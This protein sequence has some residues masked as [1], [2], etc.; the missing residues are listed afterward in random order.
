MATKDSFE[1]TMSQAGALFMK[2]VAKALD[3]EIEKYRQLESLYL[4]PPKV[5]AKEMRFALEVGFGEEDNLVRG[6]IIVDWEP[7]EDYKDLQ[8]EIYARFLGGKGYTKLVP[9][10]IASTPKDVSRLAVKTLQKMLDRHL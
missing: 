6:Y 2:R 5:Y 1:E 3:I 9:T 4:E 10:R 8:I 7:D